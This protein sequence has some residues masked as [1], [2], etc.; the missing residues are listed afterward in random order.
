MTSTP[1]RPKMIVLIHETS[2]PKMIVLLLEPVCPKMFVMFLC[3]SL[4]DM[5]HHQEDFRHHARY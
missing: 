3:D 4:N 5:F 1:S 2:F